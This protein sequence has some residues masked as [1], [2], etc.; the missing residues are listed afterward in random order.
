MPS[1]D[2]DAWRDRL[3]D[4]LYRPQMCLGTMYFGTTVDEDTSV[5]ILDRFVERGGRL[6]DTANCYSFW[7]DGGTGE[8]SERL[9]GRWLAGAPREELVLATKV[10][11]RPEPAGASWPEFAEGLSEKVIVE[12]VDR[13][14]ERLASAS[15][16][17]LYAHI[18]DPR[19]PQEETA[20][21]FAAVVASG[22]A[23]LVGASNFTLE[24][25]RSALAVA[26]AT[27][28][29]RYEAL[30]VRAS[31]LPPLSDADFHP[32]VALDDASRAFTAGI[33]M[34]VFGYSPLLSGAY[35]RTDRPLPDA[36]RAAGTDAR[37]DR[38]RR[39]AADL[40]ATPHQVVLAHLVRVQDVVPVLGV[41]SVQQLDEALDALDITDVAPLRELSAA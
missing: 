30:Q 13:S 24:R 21:G 33:G 3:R 12:Q 36:Y 41:S 10:G 15:I 34:T 26:D 35:S 23:G 32:Q 6:V 22:R 1:T 11:S 7:V 8:E 19:T 39:T 37:L 29:P 17:L 38:L 20:A 14:L 25:L 4:Q 28:R 31:L 2:Q 27:G 18:D 5:R 9:L 16:D 40:G